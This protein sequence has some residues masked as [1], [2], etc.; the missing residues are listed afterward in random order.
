M[1]ILRIYRVL[2]P[3]SPKLHGV[4]PIIVTAFSW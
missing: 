4:S 3:G 2:S 1:N